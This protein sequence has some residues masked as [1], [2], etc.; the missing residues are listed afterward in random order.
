MVM[1]DKSIY[2]FDYETGEIIIREKDEEAKSRR[3]IWAEEQ[4]AAN[5]RG[6][7]PGLTGQNIII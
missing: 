2:S 4:A 1:I 7:E 5:K 3:E 6:Q